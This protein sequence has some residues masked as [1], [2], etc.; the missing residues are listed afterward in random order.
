ME[1]VAGIG[2]LVALRLRAKGKGNE[3]VSSETLACDR[4]N[5]LDAGSSG[6][7]HKQVMERKSRE[8]QR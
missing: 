3:R 7:K 6:R 5:Y 4:T 8:A 1:F 2:V